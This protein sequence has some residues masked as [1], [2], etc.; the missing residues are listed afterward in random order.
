MAPATTTTADTVAPLLVLFVILL[1]GAALVSLVLALAESRKIANLEKNGLTVEGKVTSFE[2][3]S[4]GRGGIV[5]RASYV[6]EFEGQSYSCE[7]RVKNDPFLQFQT[8][9]LRLYLAIAPLRRER[10]F[11][12]C[13]IKAH[14]FRQFGKFGKPL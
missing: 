2:I 3:K 11:D 6:Y 14:P 4:A 9:D 13:I 7:Q 1:A 8:I 12:C 10:C 5:C